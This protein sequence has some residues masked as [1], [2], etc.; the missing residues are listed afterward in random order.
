MK[1]V[2]L[3]LLLG[4]IS[5]TAPTK[6]PISETPKAIHMES[7]QQENENQVDTQSKTVEDPHKIAERFKSENAV[8]VHSVIQTSLWGKENSVIV[9]YESRYTEEGQYPHEY[10][11]IDAYLL[12]PNEKND[13]KKVLISRFE[14]DNVDTEIQ[15]V[16]FANADSDSKKELIILSTCFHSLE[17]LYDGTEYTTS[18]FDDFDTAK[19]PKK[20]TYLSKVSAQLDGGFEGFLEDNPDSKAQFKTAAEIKKELKKLGY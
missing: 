19:P 7:R 12:I 1:Y 18:V 15:S 8:I 20:M 9:F 2:F 17:Y 10:Q 4:L 13:Y 14:D 3:F 5:C 6:K 11:Y 16:F